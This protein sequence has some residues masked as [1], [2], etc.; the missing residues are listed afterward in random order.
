MRAWLPRPT[1]VPIRPPTSRPAT[2]VLRQRNVP[3]AIAL[4]APWPNY[5][6]LFSVTTSAAAD[7]SPE[8]WARAGIEDAPGLAGQFIWRVV[9]GLRLERRPSLDH[10]GGWKIGDRD[11]NWVRLEAASWFLTAQIVVQVDPEQVSVATFI[12]YDRPMAAVIWPPLSIGAPASDAR[13]AAPGSRTRAEAAMDTPLVWHIP[14]PHF[15][16]VDYYNAAKARAFEDLD[17]ESEH[18]RR[19]SRSRNHGHP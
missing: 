14:L 13:A 16:D 18:G 12:R 4:S 19:R 9:L 1:S 8:R 7:R 3:K 17:N 10:V 5:V 6:D 11:D 15:D 2:T